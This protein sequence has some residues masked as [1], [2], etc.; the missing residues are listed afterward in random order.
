MIRIF[1]VPVQSQ[2]SFGSTYQTCLYPANKEWSLYRILLQGK[3]DEDTTGTGYYY[4]VRKMKTQQGL[5]I[6]TR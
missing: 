1:L 4:K 5:D 3:K 6:I 2:Q